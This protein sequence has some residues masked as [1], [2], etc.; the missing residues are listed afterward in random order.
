MP[1]V[2][3]FCSTFTL[4]TLCR[5]GLLLCRVCQGVD[6]NERVQQVLAGGSTVMGCMAAH[7]VDR[8]H[9]DPADFA[10]WSCLLV[11]LLLH[12]A[13]QLLLAAA[14]RMQNKLDLLGLLDTLGSG[15]QRSCV[16]QQ[17]FTCH[18]DLLSQ[19]E[20]RHPM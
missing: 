17:P 9:V 11:L 18:S 20:S 16:T 4:S 12:P 13:S 8:E 5:F 3:L 14:I 2:C 1:V 6:F 10:H 19:S 15:A 7:V